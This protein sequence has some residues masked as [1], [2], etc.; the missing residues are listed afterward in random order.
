MDSQPEALPAVGAYPSPGLADVLLAAADEA[1][2]PVEIRGDALLES[3]DPVSAAIHFDLT[4]W[5]PYVKVAGTYVAFKV[6]DGAFGEVGAEVLRRFGRMVND[7]VDRAPR[8]PFVD[9]MIHYD[10]GNKRTY[11]LPGVDKEAAAAAIPVDVGFEATHPLDNARFWHEG[12]WVGGH[13]ALERERLGAPFMESAGARPRQETFAALQDLRALLGADLC[14]ASRGRD[15]GIQLPAKTPTDTIEK[16]LQIVRGH[17]PKSAVGLSNI[18]KHLVVEDALQADT[19]DVAAATSSS[20]TWPTSILTQLPDRLYAVCI[21]KHTK[22]RDE[23]TAIRYVGFAPASYALSDA[24]YL[25][26]VDDVLSVLDNHLSLLLSTDDA[27]PTKDVRLIPAVHDGKPYVTTEANDDLPNNLL[28][29][30][31]LNRAEKLR[32]A[33]PGPPIPGGGIKPAR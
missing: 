6:L 14:Y 25:L 4:P 29:K 22:H 13:V 18:R 2:I 20:D 23:H 24:H 16:A 5:L 32:L 27:D 30:R 9:V 19:H 3:A 7:T 15:I 1:R 17:L 21:D 31:P 10:D 28:Q 33:N 11:H 12:R 8:K 26:T